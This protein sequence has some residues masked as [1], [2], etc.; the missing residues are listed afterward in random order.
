[1]HLEDF[2]TAVQV[3][4]PTF[5]WVNIKGDFAFV[6]AN[7]NETVTLTFP[8]FDPLVTETTDT[9]GADGFEVTERA[10]TPCTPAPSHVADNKEKVNSHRFTRASYIKFIVPRAY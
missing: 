3:P 7:A 5:T 10:S 4:V 8:F 9:T 6:L 2:L 1:V